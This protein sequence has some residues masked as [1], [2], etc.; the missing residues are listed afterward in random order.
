MGFFDVLESTARY[1]GMH[2]TGIHR[3]NVR[4]RFL[5]EPFVADIEGSRVLD[6]A[7]H[8]GRWSY[9]LAGAGAREVVSIEAR[10]ELMD[11]FAEFPDTEFKSSIRW[12]HGDIF[13]ELEALVEAGETFDVVAVYGIFYHVM[14][15][16]RLLKLIRA[17]RPRLVVVDSEFVQADEA[18]IDVVMEDTE[19]YLNSTAHLDGQR[20]APTGAPSR[21]AVEMMATSLGWGVEWADWTAVPK[22]ERRWLRAYY[23]GADV[24]RRRDTCWFRPAE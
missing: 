10:Q 8:D 20:R 12:V 2:E 11:Q 13:D 6:L 1:A 3:L 17:L 4:H 24:R 22:E 23:R 19:K 9:A 15:H 18:V 5:V 7:A 14:D 16:Y 21:S